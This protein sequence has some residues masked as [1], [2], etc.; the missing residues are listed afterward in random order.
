MRARLLFLAGLLAPP[1]APALLPPAAGQTPAAAPLDP[2]ALCIAAIKPDIDLMSMLCT[3][4]PPGAEWTI[5]Q[6][7]RA[8]AYYL[9]AL[10][11][12]YRADDRVDREIA[13]ATRFL[14]GLPREQWGNRVQDCVDRALRPQSRLDRRFEE[15]RQQ[16]RREHRAAG[17]E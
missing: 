10:D 11:A 9:G 4:P 2:D 5:R 14:D 1:L 17:R 8:V 12:R 3:G 13:A 7:N 6:G 16:L 15:L